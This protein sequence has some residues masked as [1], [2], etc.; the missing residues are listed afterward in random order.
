M[1]SNGE[2]S[3][4]VPTANDVREP[5]RNHFGMISGT[6]YE[7]AASGMRPFFSQSVA[8]RATTARGTAEG[9]SRQR[10]RRMLL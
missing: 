1:R 5:R 3:L 4:M 10:A 2:T 8:V 6:L 7:P 9:F